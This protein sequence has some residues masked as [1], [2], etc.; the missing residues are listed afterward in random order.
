MGSR[1]PHGANGGPR[2]GLGPK[3]KAKIEGYEEWYDEGEWED[4][5]YDD[6]AMEGD[7]D[8][9][10]GSLMAALDNLL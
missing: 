7:G 10:K 3:E 8:E 2:T 6:E 5:D 4:G 9:W 1:V